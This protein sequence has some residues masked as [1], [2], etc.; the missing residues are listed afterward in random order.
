MT[1]ENKE[2]SGETRIFNNGTI[3]T[4][5]AD[6]CTAEA[7]VVRNGRIEAV[8]TNREVSQLITDE[9]V[10]VDQTSSRR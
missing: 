3:L 1:T 6:N 7:V 4:M 10:V 5:D 2:Q 9:R 8:G